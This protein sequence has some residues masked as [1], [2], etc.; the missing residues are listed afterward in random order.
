MPS[1]RPSDVSRQLRSLRGER[2]PLGWVFMVGQRPRGPLRPTREAAL[3]DAVEAG[4]AAVCLDH[5]RIFLE[6]LTWIA[7]IWP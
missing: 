1:F 6:P 7:P 4:E 3:R 2:A 5:R